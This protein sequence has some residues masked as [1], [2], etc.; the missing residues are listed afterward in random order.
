MPVYQYNWV[1][2]TKYLVLCLP[3]APPGGR[4]GDC[5]GHMH[6]LVGVMVTVL[7]ICI[8]WWTFWWLCWSYA[9]LVGRLVNFAGHMHGVQTEKKRAWSEMVCKWR[10]FVYIGKSFRH[11]S[12]VL[13]VKIPVQITIQNGGMVGL[14]LRLWG[15]DGLSVRIVVTVPG[16]GQTKGSTILKITPKMSHS[17]GSDCFSIKFSKHTLERRPERAGLRKCNNLYSTVLM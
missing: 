3:Y 10:K 9:P 15:W 8:T 1:V 4:F 7:V 6:H 14:K 5:A 12:G 11:V 17:F 13:P 16:Q 2:V